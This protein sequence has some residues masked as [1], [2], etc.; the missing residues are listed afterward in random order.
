MQGWAKLCAGRHPVPGT[1]VFKHRSDL[2]KQFS[3]RCSPLVLPRFCAGVS[4]QLNDGLA[5][6]MIWF[7]NSN[8]NCSVVCYEV[9]KASEWDMFGRFKCAN[10]SFQQC[11]FG[12]HAFQ[13]H[14]VPIKVAGDLSDL[15][16]RSWGDLGYACSERP[17]IDEFWSHSWHGCKWQKALTAVFLNNGMTA[18]VLASFGA[19][20]PIVLFG[21]HLLP[22]FRFQENPPYPAQPS[23]CL[24]TGLLLYCLVLSCCPRSHRIFL[25][26]LCIDQKD[27]RA[28]TEAIA[29]MG[30]ILKCSDTLVVLWDPS[31][32]KR[33]WVVFEMAAFLH[34]RSAGQKANLIIRPTLLGPCFISLPVAM[35]CVLLGIHFIPWAAY[36]DSVDELHKILWPVMGSVSFVGFYFSVA[37]LRRYFRSVHA[38]EHDFRQFSV[39][40]CLCWCCSIGHRTRNGGQMACDRRL[41]CLCI[42]SWY[43]S[44]EHFEKQVQTEVLDNLT[45]QLSSEV[46]TYKQIATANLPLLWHAMDAVTLFMHMF[47]GAF[48]LPAHEGR[49]YYGSLSSR[50]LQCLP[51]ERTAGT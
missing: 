6:Y 17:R 49:P 16:L 43:G 42:E 19:A 8:S 50:R 12:A 27:E 11:L 10:P 48:D 33:L 44:L 24:A 4:L 9:W 31:C 28:K 37:R 22:A 41:V 14:A 51:L 18:S 38:L 13:N 45:E 34:S 46:F 32:T 3:G 23:W 40:G 35:S 39:Q 25:D 2:A 15:T 26:S 5:V 1:S 7:Q 21:T 20:M 29:S 47:W 30:A 36:V